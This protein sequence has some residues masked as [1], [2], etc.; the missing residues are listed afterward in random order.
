ML[1]SVPS[2][3]F[4]GRMG[5]VVI[6]AF[7]FG[8]PLP[9]GAENGTGRLSD[10]AIRS[11]VEEY[12]YDRNRVEFEGRFHS[13]S[14]PTMGFLRTDVSGTLVPGFLLNFDDN[15]DGPGFKAAYYLPLASV[16]LDDP[17]AWNYPFLKFWI[18]YDEADGSASIENINPQGSQLL[19]PGLG[20]NDYLV[21][22]N[23]VSLTISPG[24]TQIEQ[25]TLDID[26]DI[27]MG[28]IAIGHVLDHHERMVLKYYAG[29]YIASGNIDTRFWSRTRSGATTVDAWYNTGLDITRYGINAGFDGYIQL[30]EP[31]SVAGLFLILGGGASIDQYDIEGT[32]WFNLDVNWN[33]FERQSARVEDNETSF[34]LSAS[35]GLKYTTDRWSVYTR[36]IY[37]YED[38]S[39]GVE[40]L[41][42]GQPARI[43]GESVD[44]WALVFGASVK[45]P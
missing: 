22:P 17:A 44:V 40:R 39:P 28:G 43:V 25:A 32:D 6:T 31:E 15:I 29:P 4:R 24:F 38:F 7:M 20:S 9:A 35:L 12:G 16:G 3:P 37:R 19:F 36:G 23:G 14:T 26:T 33:P 27:I 10:E 5:A 34:T 2:R 8:L 41:G 45:F 11:L 42:G 13:M 18:D 21:N 30:N 1:S